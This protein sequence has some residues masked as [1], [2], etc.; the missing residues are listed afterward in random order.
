MRKRKLLE[1]MVILIHLIGMIPSRM[2]TCVENYPVV[3]F[4]Y[5]QLAKCQLSSIKLRKQDKT[6]NDT[7]AHKNKLPVA[8]HGNK[9][10]ID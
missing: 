4:K 3:H 10:T 8:K 6:E 2:Y 9:I 1:V 5:V 7:R